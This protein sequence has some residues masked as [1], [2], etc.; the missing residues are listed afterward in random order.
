[1]AL[2]F[3]IVFWAIICLIHQIESW[4]F[5]VPFLSLQSVHRQPKECKERHKVLVDRS[6]GDGAD[7]A[8]DS[9]SSQHYHNTLPGIPKVCSLTTL[10]C[11]HSLLPAMY[12]RCNS[13]RCDIE[14]FILAPAIFFLKNECL[15]QHH[16]NV[17]DLFGGVHY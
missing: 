14:P 13:H 9:G 2:F 11:R 6:S 1:M 5:L 7:S 4:V 17:R 12:A 16:C 10:F 3:I 15:H 8:E